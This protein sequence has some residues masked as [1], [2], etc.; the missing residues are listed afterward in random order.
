MKLYDLL[1]NIIALVAY[2]TKFKPMIFSREIVQS[3]KV[4]SAYH[5][6]R[7]AKSV[8]LFAIKDKLVRRQKAQLEPMSSLEIET[9][10]YN[11]LQCYCFQVRVKPA[12]APLGILS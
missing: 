4:V 11:V 1:Y 6:R 12:Y 3:A 5:Q 9:L 7:K 10:F 2:S 8:G